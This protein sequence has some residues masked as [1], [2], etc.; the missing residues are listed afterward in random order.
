MGITFSLPVLCAD[1][2]PFANSTYQRFMSVD[3]GQAVIINLPPIDCY[4]APT[5]Y[6]RNVLTGVRIMDGIQHYHLTV[7]NQLIIL[8]TQ[9]NR[10]NGTMFRAQARN[11]YTFESSHSPT[12]LISVNGKND[13]FW[14]KVSYN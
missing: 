13:F 12:F 1:M 10:D 11:I 4:P 14:P 3:E 8:S 5:V 9:M 6:W 7:D 2:V